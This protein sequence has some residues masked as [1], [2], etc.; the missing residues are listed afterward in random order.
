MKIS[1]IFTSIQGET[2]FAGLPF[3]FVRLSG[4]NLRCSYCD[5]AYA[6]TGGTK[7]LLADI[8]AEVHR[9]ARPFEGVR[10][11]ECGV[12]SAE[13]KT[14]QASPEGARCRA[15]CGPSI[16]HSAFLLAVSG[17]FWASPSSCF[18]RPCFLTPCCP[19][20]PLCR[21]TRM[22]RLSNHLARVQELFALSPTKG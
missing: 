17:C 8:N 19:F 14:D 10:S 2:S 13:W 9:L 20:I 4:C 21:R 1:E 12:R 11:A 3:T 5:T 6:F 7:R 15:Q 22:W 18:L 16:L